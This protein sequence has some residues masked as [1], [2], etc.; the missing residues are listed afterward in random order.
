MFWILKKGNMDKIHNVRKLHYVV[1][2]KYQSHKQ[3]FP[4]IRVNPKR[5]HV[6]DKTNSNIN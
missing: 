2:V 4:R 3:V 6:T 1:R 5:T